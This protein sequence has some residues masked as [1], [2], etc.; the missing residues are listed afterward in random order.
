MFCFCR[1]SGCQDD[2][3]GLISNFRPVSGPS[4][5]SLE[6]NYETEI[7]PS[8]LIPPPTMYSSDVQTIVENNSRYVK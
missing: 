2:N 5:R 7:L 1:L 6:R 3:A 8:T 4:S